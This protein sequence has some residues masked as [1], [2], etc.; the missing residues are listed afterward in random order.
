MTDLIK[1][2]EI[3]ETGRQRLTEWLAGVLKADF[4]PE[5]FARV[6]IDEFDGS[7]PG[8]RTMHIEVRGFHSR[9]GNP[10]IYSFG[11]DELDIVTYDEDGNLVA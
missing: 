6:F 3:N 7:L 2:A 8:E 5:S 11:A 1:T 10:V 9:T 4:S